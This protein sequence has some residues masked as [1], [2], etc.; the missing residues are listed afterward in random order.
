MNANIPFVD[1][2]VINKRDVCVLWIACLYIYIGVS[3]AILC[4]YSFS[5]ISTSGS[6]LLS[7]VKSPVTD[8]VKNVPVALVMLC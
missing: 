8:E 2:K 3:I 4:D 1:E 7:K 6:S 5:G